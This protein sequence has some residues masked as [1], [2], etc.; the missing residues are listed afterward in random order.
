M[1]IDKAFDQGTLFLIDSK[2]YGQSKKSVEDVRFLA[3]YSDLPVIVK[4]IQSPE[5][6]MLAIGAGTSV[7]AVS[8]PGW[9]LIR[10]C[11]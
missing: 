1:L 5:D 7:I 10:W 3:E 8:N 9:S 4:G 11:S 2:I 6:A